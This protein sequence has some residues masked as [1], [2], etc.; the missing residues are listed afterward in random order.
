MLWAYNIGGNKM[1]V[2]ISIENVVKRY[3]RL[4]IIPGL[5]IY[6]KNG[7]FLLCLAP[8]GAARPPF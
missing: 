1:S 8:Q 4:T 3:D 2:A 6:I 5:S 7:E